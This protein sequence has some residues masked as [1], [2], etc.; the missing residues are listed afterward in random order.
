MNKL[1][2]LRKFYKLTNEHNQLKSSY[3]QAEAN[4]WLNKYDVHINKP[5]VEVIL[6]YK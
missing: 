6:S 1:P 2:H 4:Y 3:S 5:K